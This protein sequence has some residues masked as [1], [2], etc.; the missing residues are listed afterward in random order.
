MHTNRNHFRIQTQAITQYS[1]FIL[2]EL[3]RWMIFTEFH[4]W[5]F[6]RMPF[7]IFISVT[8]ETFIQI[9]WHSDLTRFPCLFNGYNSFR[10]SKWNSVLL[11][12]EFLQFIKKK[13]THIPFMGILEFPY[14]WIGDNNV[15]WLLCDRSQHFIFHLNC[16]LY[17]ELKQTT[18]RKHYFRIAKCMKTF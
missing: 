18:K 16:E 5:E 17:F 11:F 7:C 15:V 14:N 2:V 10:S 3:Y 1:M 12:I 8:N 13:N 4:A 9:S 6:I